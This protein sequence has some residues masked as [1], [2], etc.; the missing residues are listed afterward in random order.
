MLLRS[1]AIVNCRDV[2]HWDQCY[3]MWYSVLVSEPRKWIMFWIIRNNLSNNFNFL[4]CLCSWLH[5][6]YW[7]FWSIQEHPIILSTVC[8]GLSVCIWKRCRWCPSFASCRTLGYVLWF[9]SCFWKRFGDSIYQMDSYCHVLRSW[10]NIFH[11]LRSSNCLLVK[12]THLYDPILFSCWVQ[13][14]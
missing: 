14:I 7:P 11:V 6:R 5:V 1:S 4:L 13:Y 2:L 12:M 9:S 3:P 10:V 8:C